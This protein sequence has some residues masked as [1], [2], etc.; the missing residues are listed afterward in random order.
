ML[1][2]EGIGY[3]NDSI[4]TNAVNTKQAEPVSNN[5][6]DVLLSQETEK[7][8]NEGKTYDLNAIFKEA[9]ETYGISEDL[10]KAVGYVESRFNPYDT[11]S[12]GAMGIMQLMPET[13]ASLGVTDAYDPYQNIMGAAKLLNGL[14]DLYDG[15]ITLMLAA[16]NAGAGAVKKYGGVPPY[17]SVNHYISKVYDALG[18][19][20][21]NEVPAVTYTKSNN[22][23]STK[24][25]ESTAISNTESEKK[26]R[27]HCQPNR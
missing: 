20:V 10:L 19:G 15:D 5:S 23:I 27:K 26:R 7:L 2:I 21:S 18:T 3:V 13:A 22:A 9:S 6:F 24:Q 17:D 25:T 14:S 16:Y 8:N 11:S 1:F 4:T 12:S